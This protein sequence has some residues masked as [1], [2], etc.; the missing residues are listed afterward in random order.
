V[1]GVG[2]AAFY[3]T[4]SLAPSGFNFISGGTACNMYTANFAPGKALM[5]TLAESILEG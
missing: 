4:A 3:F 5:T 1:P 2:D